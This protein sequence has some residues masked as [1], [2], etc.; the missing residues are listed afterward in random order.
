MFEILFSMI[1]CYNLKIIQ[2]IQIKL[3][4]NRRCIEE[5]TTQ[6]KGKSTIVYNTGPSN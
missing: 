4:S 5:T 3:R 2:V 1:L 6:P